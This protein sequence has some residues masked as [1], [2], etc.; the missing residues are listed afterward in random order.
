M[1]NYGLSAAE[2]EFF[3]AHDV[4]GDKIAPIE[5]DLLNTL[6]HYRTANP[7]YKPGH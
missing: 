4:L 7:T 5:D 2:V 1:R 6:R 3:T